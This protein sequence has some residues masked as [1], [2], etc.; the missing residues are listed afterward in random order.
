MIIVKKFKP[1]QIR[2]TLSLIILFS[3][4]YFYLLA[5]SASLSNDEQI[6]DKKLSHLKTEILTNAEKINSLFTIT[7]F[8]L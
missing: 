5:K 7:T 6:L 1:Y 8:L 2:F 3:F 4:L